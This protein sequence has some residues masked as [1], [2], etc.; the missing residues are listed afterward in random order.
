MQAQ[1]EPGE[2]AHGIPTTSAQLLLHPPI[3]RWRFL[4]VHHYHSVCCPKRRVIASQT[5]KQA[6]P[7]L[8]IS[9][10]AEARSMKFVSVMH[11]P[12]ETVKP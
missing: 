12:P 3:C 9:S 8:C 4:H 10:A 11:S 7:L 6:L 2:S 5:T 1:D